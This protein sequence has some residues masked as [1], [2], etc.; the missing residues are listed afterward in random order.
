MRTCD[1]GKKG[2]VQSYTIAGFIVSSFPFYSILILFRPC[3]NDLSRGHITFVQ[4]LS[5]L[6][7]R[8][9]HVIQTPTLMMMI[10]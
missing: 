1:V 2:V 10:G 9:K 7:I 6:R 8:Q 3:P 4:R 5:I